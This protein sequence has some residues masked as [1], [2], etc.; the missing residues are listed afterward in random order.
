M[1]RYCRTHERGWY[2]GGSQAGRSAQWLDSRR[3]GWQPL[4][5]PLV[6]AALRLAYDAGCSAQITITPTHCDWCTGEEKER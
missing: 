6:Q 2:P 5:W 4:C 1:L 3:P